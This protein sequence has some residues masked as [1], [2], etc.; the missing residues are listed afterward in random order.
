MNK[1]T[2]FNPL[3]AKKDMEKT[4]PKEHFV[5]PQDMER[6]IN[7]AYHPTW[8]RNEAGFEQQLDLPIGTLNLKENLSP[9]NLPET[10]EQLFDNPS[11]GRACILN[12]NLL[13]EPDFKGGIV[14]IWPTKLCPIGCAHCMF[15]SP[16]SNE[17]LNGAISNQLTGE[18]TQRAIDFTNDMKADIVA[19]SGGGEPMVERE[20]SFD[21][22]KNVNAEN[23]HMITNGYWGDNTD[24][25]ESFFDDLS[26]AF[27]QRKEQQ[28][29]NAKF[30]LKLSVDE[31]H[32]HHLPVSNVIGIL[33]ESFNRKFDFPIEIRLKSIFREDKAVNELLENLQIKYPQLKIEEVNPFK[34]KLIIAEDREIY[35]T[36]KNRV[37]S[38]RGAVHQMDGIT[39]NYNKEYTD[40]ISSQIPG[41][42]INPTNQALGGDN[43][44][45]TNGVN[46]TIEY[47]GSIK[48][49]EGT[50]LD[51]VPNINDYDF[52]G[53]Q[54]MIFKDPI[55]YLSR[56]ESPEAVYAIAE[57]I[58]P[59]S[60]KKTRAQNA[61]YYNLERL[62]DTPEKRLYATI[63][64]CQILGESHPEIFDK[65]PNDP[66]NFW[67]DVPVDKLKSMLKFEK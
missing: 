48:L 1:E 36:F 62:L 30:V 18:E 64:A 28:R 49:L 37:T 34:L 32:Q 38:G 54:Q 3:V 39:A 47:D 5:S 57:E 7:E 21:I 46:Y 67:I 22:I 9:E 50:P 42:R 23:I 60:L 20:K 53:A 44:E 61:L 16:R 55:S 11:V 33:E 14:Y 6:A 65:N 13:K 40:F 19:L 58:N 2:S 31:E 56:L 27:R 41:G 45:F 17:K 51:N 66:K 35:V 63:R 29:P 43:V 8:M 52:R 26:S 15:G 59:E 25:I 12:H 24:G 10:V 4:E